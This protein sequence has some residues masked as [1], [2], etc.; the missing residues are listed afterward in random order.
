VEHAGEPQPCPSCG[1]TFGKIAQLEQLL[2]RWL[3]PRQWRADLV[4]PS[5]AYLIEKLWTSNGQGERLYMGV[6]PKYTNYNIFRHLVTR[7]LIEGVNDG[8]VELTFPEDPLVEDP[9]YELNIV[10]SERFAKTIEKLFPE[11]DWD[12]TIEMPAEPANE[13]EA[14]EPAEK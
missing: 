4:K 11:V 10:D 12:E 6:A 9:Q 8:W 1:A 5:V 13:E 2:N 3:E 7:A 14:A